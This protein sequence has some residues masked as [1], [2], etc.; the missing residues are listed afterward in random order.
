MKRE[1]REVL[2]AMGELERAMAA[3]ETGIAGLGRGHTGKDYHHSQPAHGPTIARRLEQL[4]AA[5]HAMEI[6]ARSL[7]THGH[8]GAVL[9]GHMAFI[10]S[11]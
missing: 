7:T 10:D 11:C 6:P 3:Q 2:H 9:S 4:C 1:L 8:A 5:A